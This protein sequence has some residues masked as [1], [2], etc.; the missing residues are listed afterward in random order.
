[1]SDETRDPTGGPP[2]PRPPQDPDL[3]LLFALGA[4]AREQEA[5]MDWPDDEALAPIEGEEAGALFDAVLGQAGHGPPVEVLPSPAA[6]SAPPGYRR[7][8]FALAATLLVAVVGVLAL[9]LGGQA[10]LPDYA[11][12]S[13][14]GDQTMRA[15]PAPTTDRAR[16]QPGSRVHLIARPAADVTGAVEARVFIRQAGAFTRLEAPVQ[17]SATGAVRLDAVAGESIALPEGDGEL[18]VLIRPAGL[19]A[20]D[21]ALLAAPDPAPAR[22]LA[23]RFHF[24]R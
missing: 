17:I 14:A 15:D 22:R 1:M 24:S 23:H 20:T 21:D 11:L 5:D 8:A 19:E 10:G 18:V 6:L 12:T 3:D 4:L 16:Y 2:G 9:R 13:G 7:W